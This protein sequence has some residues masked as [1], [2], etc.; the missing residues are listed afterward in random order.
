[1]LLPATLLA[2]IVIAGCGRN[3]FN[4]DPRP[5][6]PAEVSMKVATDG[7]GVS[8]KEFGAGLVNFTIANLTN[9]T[10]SLAIH[11]PVSANSDPIAPGDTGTIKVNVTPGNYEAS[12]DGFA[13]RPFSFTVGPE[14]PSGKNDLLL[15]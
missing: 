7:V 12:V 13:V 11:G 2:V 9:Q 6:I 15:P 3:D 8:P 5:P 4:N 1:M 14:R 10:G